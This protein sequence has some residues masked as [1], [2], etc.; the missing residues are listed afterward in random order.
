M[1]WQSGLLGG[2]VVS[3]YLHV[4]NLRNDL[5]SGKFWNASDGSET[6]YIYFGHDGANGLIGTSTGPI[7]LGNMGNSYL[8]VKRRRKVTLER[9]RKMTHSFV[10][11]TRVGGS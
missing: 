11:A 5:V 9:R 10:V 6:E 7:L 8:S 4:D 1:G 2:N 3:S